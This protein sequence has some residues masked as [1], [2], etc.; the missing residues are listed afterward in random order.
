MTIFDA[1]G[2]DATSPVMMSQM[3]TGCQL[4]GVD[5][6]TGIS[7]LLEDYIPIRLM[8]LEQW[9]YL[10]NIHSE[11]FNLRYARLSTAG[12]DILNRDVTGVTSDRH[13]RTSYVA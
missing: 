9:L 10:S 2:R 4:E 8:G 13:G 3:L 6:S 1:L 11:G 5:G 12:M 7:W